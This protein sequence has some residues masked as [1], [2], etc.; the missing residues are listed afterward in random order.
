MVSPLLKETPDKYP[1]GE[2]LRQLR[3]R[4]K[5]DLAELGKHSGLF[6]ALLPSSRT[7]NSARV[8]A[9]ARRKDRLRRGIRLRLGR[10]AL[11]VGAD[12]GASRQWQLSVV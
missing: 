2:Q 12:Q 5:M 4:R 8:F 1:V 3:L 10:L 6:P 9:M 11:K 7:A